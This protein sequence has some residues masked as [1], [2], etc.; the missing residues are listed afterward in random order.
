MSEQDGLVALTGLL[1]LIE[2]IERSIDE[3]SGTLRTAVA[4]THTGRSPDRRV[5]ATVFRE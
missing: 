2:D 3:V 1:E 5:T 4:A